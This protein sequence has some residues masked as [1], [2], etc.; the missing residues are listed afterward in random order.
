MK[1]SQKE[2]IMSDQEYIVHLLSGPGG[3]VFPH[4]GKVGK[5]LQFEICLWGTEKVVF[6]VRLWKMGRRDNQGRY[7]IKGVG[8]LGI[9]LAFEGVWNPIC[10]KGRVKVTPRVLQAI[11]RSYWEEVGRWR[12]S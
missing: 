11:Y 5:V 7:A 3:A 4:E 1:T 6:P 9:S 12:L 10:Q 2:G 8:I